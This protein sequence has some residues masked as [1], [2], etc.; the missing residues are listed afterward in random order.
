MNKLDEI[1]EA[2]NNISR[3]E[4]V[5]NPPFKIGDQVR[6]NPALTWASG[7]LGKVS[8]VHRLSYNI[9]RHEWH[10]II[11]FSSDHTGS[12]DTTFNLKPESLVRIE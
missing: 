8:V 12:I 2:L 10:V 3:A 9:T 5:D 6:V 7:V 4:D 1:A 11:D